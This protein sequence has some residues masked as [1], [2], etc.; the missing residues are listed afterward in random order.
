M[1]KYVCSI[2]GYVYNEDVGTSW[3]DLSDDWDCPLCR[4]PKGAFMV[5]SDDAGALEEVNRM[6]SENVKKPSE[7]EMDISDK[8]EI[9]KEKREVSANEISAICSNLAKGC[10]KQY[11]E[12]E[13]EAFWKLSKYYEGIATGKISSKDNFAD[14]SD[15]LESLLEAIN[16]SLAKTYKSANVVAAENEDRGA[17]RALLWSEKVTKML[18]SILN[19]YGKM[20]NAYLENK[21]VYVCEICGFVSIGTEKPKICPVCKVPNIKIKEIRRA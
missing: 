4:A 15:V 6:M 20:G 11:L 16:I 1:K 18:K 21:K 12:E 8:H 5:E 2:C 13:S 17:K 7:K 19:Q 9:S 3:K 14:S 10:E